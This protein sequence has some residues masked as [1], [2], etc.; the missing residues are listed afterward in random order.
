M[1]YKVKYIENLLCNREISLI[2]FDK[3]EKKE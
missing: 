3:Y 1:I 2:N